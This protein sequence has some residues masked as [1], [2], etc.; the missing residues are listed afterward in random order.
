[1]G[2]QHLP[3]R[4]GRDGAVSQLVNDDGFEA[5]GCRDRGRC[6]VPGDSVRPSHDQAEGQSD[7]DPPR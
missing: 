3:G 6:A 4:T 2:R 5:W 1:M 7:G